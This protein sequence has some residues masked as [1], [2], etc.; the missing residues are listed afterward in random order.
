MVPRW[1]VKYNVFKFSFCYKSSE[2]CLHFK[3][4]VEHFCIWFERSRSLHYIGWLFS[5]IYA[6]MS[7]S[8]KL[9]VVCK[10]LLLHNKQK[11]RSC[12]FCGFFFL[13]VVVA[14]VPVIINE[15]WKND[16]LWVQLRNSWL[17]QY[18]EVAAP[19]FR[20]MW[21]GRK[22][23]KPGV[24]GWVDL[25]RVKCCIGPHCSQECDFNY[26]LLCIVEKLMFISN[27]VNY[28]VL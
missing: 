9:H 1:M 28:N 27:S 6:I 18:L 8:N 16:L 24:L 15:P 19:C 4:T 12:L 13:I 2:L 23:S 25:E 14:Y 7:M 26:K 17:V 21:G 3:Y 10:V 22:R 11:E 5:L 20:N